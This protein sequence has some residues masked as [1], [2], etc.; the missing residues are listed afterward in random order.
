MSSE[1]DRVE[2]QRDLLGPD[3]QAKLRQ[4][5]VL[6]TR[7]GGVGGA[8]AQQLAHAGVGKLILAHA[9]PLRLDDLNRQGL[10]AFDAI[11]KPRVETAAARLRQIHPWIEIEA[12]DENVSAANAAEL[13]KKADL[14]L[15]A[16]PLFP[17]R[18]ALNRECV[19]Q[20]KP[21]IDCAMYGFELQVTTVIPGKT[22]CLACLYPEEPPAWRRKFP[23]LGAVA[24]TAGSIGAT[25]AIKVLTGLGDPLAGRLLLAD[26]RDMSFRTVKAERRPDCAVCSRR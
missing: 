15:D 2:W 10:M 24:A 8:A 6:V 9:G 3:G 13:V 25:E 20:R 18:F 12:V 21:M 4:A 11:G 14:V 26:L 22:A 16:A 7:V 23:V 5:S 1:R 19:T 17:E